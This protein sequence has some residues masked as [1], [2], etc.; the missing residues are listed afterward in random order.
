MILHIK[1]KPN[2]IFAQIAHYILGGKGA[3][4]IT[5]GSVIHIYGCDVHTFLLNKRWVRHEIHHTLQY[6]TI[7][8]ISFLWK[9]VIESL[10]KGYYNNKYEVAARN[11]ELITL[12]EQ[13]LTVII[14]DNIPFLD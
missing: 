14:N 13:N 12:S 1:V 5:F 11:S 9:Y 7:G 4:A 6:R 3:T 10:I 8:Y 2:S